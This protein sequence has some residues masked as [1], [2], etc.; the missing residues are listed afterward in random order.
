MNKDSSS[1]TFPEVCIVEASA[2]SGKT[3]TLAKRYV[4]LLLD[5][6]LKP[7]EIPLRNIL[8]ITFTRKAAAEMKER[9]LEFLKKVALDR[10]SSEQE[11]NEVL[12]S[13]NKEFSRK[14]AGRAMTHLI[15]NYN[16]FQVQTID[17]FINSLLSACAFKLDLSAGFRIKE[18]YG[19]YLRYSLDKL[20]DGAGSDKKVLEIFDKFLKQYMYIENKS[21]WFPKKQMLAILDSLFSHSNTYGGAFER[22]DLKGKKLILQKKGIF[23]LLKKLNENL[24]EGTN[25]GFSRSLGNFLEK[26]SQGFDIDNLSDYLRPGSN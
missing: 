25:A 12:A 6:S 11:L 24:P 13:A 1:F 7:E 9:I 19:D 20:I 21:S 18:N 16:F 26:Y 15:R 5:S 22:Y 14:K 10:F 8:A 3:Y 17:S 23:S 4:R 2:G